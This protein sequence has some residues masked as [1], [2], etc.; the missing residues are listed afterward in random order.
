MIIFIVNVQPMN[1][2]LFNRIELFNEITV[3]ICTY[4]CFLFSEIVEIKIREIIG[5]CFI[6]LVSANILTNWILL[7]YSLGRAI[8]LAVKPKII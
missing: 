8:Y 6:L 3:L 1:S 4:F 7:F 5:W 2:K